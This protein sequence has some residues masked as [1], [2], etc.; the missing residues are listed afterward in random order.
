MRIDING[1]KYEVE[2][3]YLNGVDG[4]SRDWTIAIVSKLMGYFTREDG[5]SVPHFEPVLYGATK[6]LPSDRLLK[7]NGRKRALR[8]ALASSGLGKADRT[9]IWYQLLEG[10]VSGDGERYIP[11]QMRK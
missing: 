2:F 6:R 5:K 3:V 4:L 8:Y 7:T 9:S 11:P 1:E 10:S